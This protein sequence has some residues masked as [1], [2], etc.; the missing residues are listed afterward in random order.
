MTLTAAPPSR[1]R[2]RTAPSRGGPPGPPDDAGFGG[3]GRGDDGSGGGNGD[4]GDGGD[5]ES[6]ALERTPLAVWVLAIATVLA[7]PAGFL[8]AA[9]LR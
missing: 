1:R 3:G 8:A 2:P 4:R 5:D 9:L 7:M 6:G